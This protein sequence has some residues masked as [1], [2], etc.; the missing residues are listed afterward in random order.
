MA[1]IHSHG[2]GCIDYVLLKWKYVPICMFMDSCVLRVVLVILGKMQKYQKHSEHCLCLN[3]C[4]E[5]PAAS[6]HHGLCLPARDGS[7][8]GSGTL[9]AALSH[10][11]GG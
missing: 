3:F 7:V 11:D 2:T 5:H 8:Q 9:G 10:G 6:L 1:I 4:L